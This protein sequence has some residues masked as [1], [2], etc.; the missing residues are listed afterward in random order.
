MMQERDP[1]EMLGR[2]AHDSIPATKDASPVPEE[3]PDP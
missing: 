2:S 1:G 3:T